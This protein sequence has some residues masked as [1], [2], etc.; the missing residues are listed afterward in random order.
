VVML[1][2]PSL[3]LMNGKCV[4]LERG[5]EARKIEISSNPVEAAETWKNQGVQRVHLI[6]IDGARA[7][8]LVNIDIIEKI[9]KKVPL[10]VG[11]GIRNIADAERVVSTGSKIILGS[12]VIKN[13]ELLMELQGFRESLLISIDS[14]DGKVVLEGWLETTKLDP[15]KLAKKIEKF[16]S[17]IIFTA[18]ERDGMMDGPDFDAIKKMVTAVKVPIYAN[19]GISSLDDIRQLK[20]AGAYAAVVGR[21][22]YDQK[23]N[24]NEA[25]NIARF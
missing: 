13:P 19:G 23:I 18:T 5:D 12:S 10:Q 21:A 7:G 16:T 11:G 6:D 2:I 8:K 24:Y 3:S 9:A 20:E 4:I 25:A 1:V 17:G 14:K 15:F 22:F